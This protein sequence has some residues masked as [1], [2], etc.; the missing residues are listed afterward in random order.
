MFFIHP[1]RPTLA[2]FWAGRCVARLLSGYMG[3]PSWLARLHLNL[4]LCVMI[5]NTEAQDNAGLIPVDQAPAHLATQM[6]H[7]GGKPHERPATH[8]A[9]LH[10][11]Q[12]VPIAGTPYPLLDI[13]PHRFQ[14][15]SAQFTAGEIRREMTE[16]LS[17]LAG[18]N[19]G[20]LQQMCYFGDRTT[21]AS[22]LAILSD[23]FEE[24]PVVVQR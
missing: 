16:L 18:L 19:D 7:M 20:T 13:N 1:K 9:P 3:Y 5:T 23:V 6:T 2:E 14:H 11:G 17:L 12:A 10:L 24:L 21:A 15:L 8:Y 22:L 4:F